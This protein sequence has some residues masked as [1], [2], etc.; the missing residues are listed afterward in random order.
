MT[1]ANRRHRNASAD[2]LPWAD[3][4]ILQLFAE[5]ELIE[6][7]NESQP[8][9]RSTP[10]SMAS[11]GNADIE[12][13]F[14]GEVWRVTPLRRVSMSRTQRTAAVRQLAPC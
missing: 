9:R 2:L 3:P 11:C 8:H 1:I 13:V 12:A 4:Y 6:A 5:A 7:E 10:C 14:A